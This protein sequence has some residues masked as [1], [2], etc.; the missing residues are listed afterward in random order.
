MDNVVVTRGK[1]VTLESLPPYSIA[2]DGFVQGP[3]VDPEN[4]RFSF[5]HHSGCLRYCTTSA[6]MQA[7]T[8]ILL[9][10]EDLNK[11]T[12][13]C[14]DADADVCAS[15]WCLKNP[16]RCKEPLVKKLIDAIGLGDMHGGA[17]GYNGMTKVVEWI[18]DPETS[19]K[20]HDDYHKLSDDGLKSIVEAVCYRIDMYVE[21]ESAIE[22][23]KQPKHG[24]YK[25]L[26]NENEWVLIE[27]MDPHAFSNIYQAG[28]NRVV[29][30]RPQTDGSLAVTLAKRSDFVGGFPIRKFYEELNKL[31]PGWGGGSTIG[32]APRNHDGTRSKLSIGTLT[33]V[34][35][36][37][38]A[39]ENARFSPLAVISNSAPPQ[40]GVHQAPAR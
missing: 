35:D 26:R 5:D 21:G 34:I 13:Y 7:W 8:A 37:A 38:I 4:H 25:I 11:Y 20:R 29:L 22:V 31:E 39:E 6:C 33:E 14:N 36:K 2:L 23:S 19:S 3:Q 40:S 16:D 1:V 30:T 17:F 15:V 24:E 12:I 10:L 32:G 18:C 28:F 9:G 27:S